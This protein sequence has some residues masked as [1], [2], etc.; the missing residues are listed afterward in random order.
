[1]IPTRAIW[2]GVDSIVDILKKLSMANDLCHVFIPTGGGND[3]LDIRH[4]NEDACIE[5]DFGYVLI[6]KPQRLVFESFGLDEEWN[7]FRLEC[8][9]LEPSGYYSETFERESLTELRPLLYT[10]TNCAEYND[11]NGIELPD[12]ARPI[13]R[14]LSG[15]SFVIFR[16]TSMYNKVSSTYDARHNKMT[17]DEFR[18][19]IGT[20]AILLSESIKPHKA[21]KKRIELVR[22]YKYRTKNKLLTESEIRLIK[23]IVIMADLCEAESNEIEKKFNK[24]ERIGSWNKNYDQYHREPRPKE[25]ELENFLNSLSNDQ[26]VL[27]AAVM[28]GGKDGAHPW[29]IPLD[30]MIKRLKDDSDLT[31][32]ISEKMSLAEYL[33]RGIIL[34]S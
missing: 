21:E 19:Y 18:N 33:K 22:P 1:M 17:T 14:I 27:I 15:C 12:G 23:K 8:Q 34:Y 20:N 9:N 31:E 10:D 6:C 4:S 16:K 3:L 25:K 11:F 5:L 13:D 2:E 7:Y 26:L 29:G 24:E 32:S 28:N 30:L